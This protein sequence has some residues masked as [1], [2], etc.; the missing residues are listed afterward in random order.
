MDSYAE[1]LLVWHALNI[2][3]MKCDKES[4]ANSHSPAHLELHPFKINFV[5]TT[6]PFQ[7]R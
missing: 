6:L 7:H 1:I 3:T 2:L 5:V 4:N